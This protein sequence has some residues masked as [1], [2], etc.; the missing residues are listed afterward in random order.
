M[1]LLQVVPKLYLRSKHMIDELKPM[2]QIIP[3]YHFARSYRIPQLQIQR[4]R[5][6][7]PTLQDFLRSSG[8]GTGSTLENREYRLRD[9]QN[10]GTNFDDK[11]CRSFGFRSRTKATECLWLQFKSRQG[12]TE[13]LK[14]NY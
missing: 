5:V 9:P 12:H 14:I 8:S 4:F 13:R 3:I 2:G 6:R 10:F 11:C 7:F 1:Q